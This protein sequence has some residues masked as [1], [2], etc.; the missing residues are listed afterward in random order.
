MKHDFFI[1]IEWDKMIKR[2]VATPYIPVL[3]DPTDTSH[4]DVEQTGIPL[5]PPKGM[6]ANI[7]NLYEKQTEEETTDEFNEFYFSP[8]S[9]FQNAGSL[10]ESKQPLY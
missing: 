2:E 8:P 10:N 5:S 3:K 4:F 9:S 1:T 7:K 6:S